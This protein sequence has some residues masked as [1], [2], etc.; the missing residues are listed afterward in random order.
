ML[1]LVNNEPF[2]RMKEKLDII[3]EVRATL[4]GLKD[5]KVFYEELLSTLPQFVTCGP[6]SAVKSSVIRRISG[7]HLPEA[8]TLCTRIATMIQM[9]RTSKDDSDSS[10]VTVTLLGPHGTTVSTENF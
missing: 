1:N 9:R 3:D 2:S 5:D 6:Q 10:P 8:S 4:G 7:V